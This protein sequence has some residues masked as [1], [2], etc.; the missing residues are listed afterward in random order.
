MDIWH[1]I[2]RIVRIAN[3]GTLI[4]FL[5]NIWLIIIVFCPTNITFNTISPIILF[6]VLSIII[7][8]SPIGEW[9]LSFFAGAKE[10][11]RKD[12]QI[13]LIPLLE[14]V[15]SAAKKRNPTIVNSIRLKIIYDNSPNAFAIGRRTIC[16]TEGLLNLSDEEIMA[17]FAHEIGHIVYSHSVIQ[18]LIG[19]GNLFISGFLVI[20]KLMC[21]IFTSIITLIGLSTKKISGILI[22][23]IVGAIPTFLIWAWTKFCMIFLMWSMRQNEFVA[24]K[25]AYRLGWGDALAYVLDNHLCSAP[26]NG[27]LKALYSKHPTSNDRV[28]HLQMLGSNYLRLSD[29]RM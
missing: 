18:L 9:S 22:L 27:F 29:F 20:I 23:T 12:M 25:Y 6:Y 15:Y 10:I 16:V 17:V 1:R 14:V 21:W 8:L 19:G 13:R 11:K 24:D 2:G 4:F 5:L 3:L 28:A 26:E 7:G